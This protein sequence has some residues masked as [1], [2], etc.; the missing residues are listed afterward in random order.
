MHLSKEV[1]EILHSAENIAR[2]NRFEKINLDH[3]YLALLEKRDSNFAKA[4]NEYEIGFE[5][6]LKN[7]EKEF[8]SAR[9][10]NG[11]MPENP[12]AVRSLVSTKL[13]DAVA[14]GHGIEMKSVFT[15]FRF[16]GKVIAELEAIEQPERFILGFE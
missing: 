4:F 13:A 2:N 1:K 6:V 5:V 15:G 9:E 12:V 11:T 8:A 16:I 10:E 14:A 7:Y 3:L